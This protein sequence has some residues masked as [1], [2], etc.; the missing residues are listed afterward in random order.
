M[1]EEW[2]RCSCLTKPENCL[3]VILKMTA[4]GPFGPLNSSIRLS[5]LRSSHTNTLCHGYNH[6]PTV[7]TDIR[8]FQRGFR[9]ESQVEWFG[10]RE[11]ASCNYY[12][13][14]TQ[15]L[16]CM[17]T[18]NNLRFSYRA[19]L[20]KCSSLLEMNNP[21]QNTKPTFN[22]LVLPSDCALKY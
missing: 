20:D 9:A 22:A 21:M 4:H 7:P 12:D 15:I 1:R 17:K 8:I 5:E 19:P 6:V 13:S 3:F 11:N 14:W 18:G 10:L 16:V 2:L